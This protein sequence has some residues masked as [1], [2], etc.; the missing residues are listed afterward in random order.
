MKK[1]KLFV[2]NAFIPSGRYL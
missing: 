1:R 2:D